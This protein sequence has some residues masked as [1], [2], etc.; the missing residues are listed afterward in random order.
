MVSR[1]LVVCVAGLLLALPAAARAAAVQPQ[2]GVAVSGTIEFP[3][4]QR[5]SLQV[6]ARDRLTVTLGFD[7]RCRGGGIGELWMS[8][9]PARGSLTVKDGVF[10]GRLTGT[11]SALGGKRTASFSWRLSGHFTD[12]K[13]ATATVTGSARV[14][15]GSHVI[16]RCTI[17]KPATVRLT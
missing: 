3:R 7:G 11:S 12:S 1:I 4:P 15:S 5:M 14:R 16:S 8:F 9:V 17:A 2:R 10:S 6:G 13:V